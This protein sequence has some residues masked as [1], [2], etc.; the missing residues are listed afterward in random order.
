MAKL[1]ETLQRREQL[2]LE[3]ISLAEAQ[4]KQEV[5]DAAIEAAI[6]AARQIIETRLDDERAGVLV[7]ETIKDLRRHLN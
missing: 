2:S 4:A 5:R 1:E 6:A 3:K 7:D